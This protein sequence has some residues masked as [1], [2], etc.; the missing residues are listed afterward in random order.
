MPELHF[1]ILAP[2]AGEVVHI[3]EWDCCGFLKDD[4]GIAE[5]VMPLIKARKGSPQREELANC[6]RVK[7]NSELA[8]ECCTLWYLYI[9]LKSL[10]LCLQ[11]VGC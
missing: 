2:H 3:L 1:R 5:A 8:S 9:Q 6:L 7:V 4:A 10:Q 11:R